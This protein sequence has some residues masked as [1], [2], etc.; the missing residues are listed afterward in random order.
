MMP[1][2]GD[3]PRRR[4]HGA[5]FVECIGMHDWPLRRTS[6]GVATAPVD[7]LAGNLK[8]MGWTL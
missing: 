1:C 7:R 5:G 4:F 8:G 3:S 6:T 2:P